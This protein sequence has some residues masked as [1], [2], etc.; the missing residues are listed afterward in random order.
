[1]SKDTI[2]FV[3]FCVFALLVGMR[4]KQRW[5][6]WRKNKEPEEKINKNQRS[7][8]A[9]AEEPAEVRAKR[10]RRESRVRFFTIVQL[11]V[12]GGLMVY[13]IPALV[14]DFMIP[15]RVDAMN[16]ILRCLIFIF[17]IYIFVLGYFKVFHRKDK[18]KRE[19]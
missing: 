10:L 6:E 16:I 15:G 19:E 5:S 4:L 13:M 12:L 14:R 3:A 17:T 8:T 7:K 2:I 11:F 18:G 9:Q 1:M